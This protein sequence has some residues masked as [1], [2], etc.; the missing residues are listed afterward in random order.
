LHWDNRRETTTTQHPSIRHAIPMAT[1]Q[2]I[3]VWLSY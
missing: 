2:I 3:Y 1:A